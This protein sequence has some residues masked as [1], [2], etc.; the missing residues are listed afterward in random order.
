MDTVKRC[1][2]GKAYTLQEWLSLPLVGDFRDDEVFLEMRN[3]VCLSTISLAVTSEDGSERSYLMSSAPTV[4]KIAH[5]VSGDVHVLV[6]YE[7]AYE[8]SGLYWVC[9]RAGHDEFSKRV[10]IPLTVFGP[11]DSLAYHKAA[12]DVL[13]EGISLG[14]LPAV[15]A[16]WM[17][18]RSGDDG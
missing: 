11:T 17:R 13:Q 5:F 16:R 10:A 9:A 12:R 7:A 8:G 3:C 18:H 15:K 2:C 1:G 14:N 4:E 6:T